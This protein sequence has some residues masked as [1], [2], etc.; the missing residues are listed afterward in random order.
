M[1]DETQRPPP[2]P[3]AREI[4]ALRRRLATL[5][6]HELL[7]LAVELT[8]TY[9]L[10]GLGTIGQATLEAT[11]KGYDT[12]G[13]ETFA[14][15]LRRLKAQRAGDA[16]LEKFIVNGEHIQVKTPMGNVDVT[17]YRRPAA[18]AAAPSPSA[19]P[20]AVPTP[21]GSI[22]NR[23][24]HGQP[25]ASARGGSPPQSQSGPPPSASAPSAN[26]NAP[27]DPGKDPK[28]QKPQGDRFRMI[29]L[30]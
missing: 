6:K 7:E 16:V 3:M 30:D 5:E 14:G 26:P 12:V 20:A 2:E 28:D 27:K 24:L 9:V 10:D 22:Y 4:E 29:E 17:E 18:P 8:A 19:P 21:P 1:A 23:E 15:M 13:D 25:P 11:P